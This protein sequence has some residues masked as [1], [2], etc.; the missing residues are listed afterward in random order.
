MNLNYRRE[1]NESA[2][3]EDRGKKNETEC[4]GLV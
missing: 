3:E 1:K 2:V 4:L